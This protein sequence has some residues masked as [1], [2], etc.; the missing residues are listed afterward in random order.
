MELCFLEFHRIQENIVCNILNLYTRL[1][2]K[3]NKDDFF[4]DN[5]VPL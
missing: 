1:K 2:E 5:K 3:L 4:I